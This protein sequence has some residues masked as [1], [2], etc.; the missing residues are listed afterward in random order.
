MTLPAENMRTVQDL[1]DT[2]LDTAY[3]ACW[4][5]KGYDAAHYYQ[6]EIIV[7][8]A[9]PLSFFGGLLG[10]ERFPK[11]AARSG[12]DQTA[13][14]RESTADSVSNVTDVIGGMSTKIIVSV[15]A[16]A[17]LLYLIKK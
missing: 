16:V 9:S 7:R 14:A 6:T 15:V 1:T 17:A 11:Y 2:E 8:L 5:V 3:A 10:V 12:F 13:A 4:D